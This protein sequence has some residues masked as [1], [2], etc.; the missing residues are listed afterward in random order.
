MKTFVFLISLTFSTYIFAGPGHGHGHGPVDTCKKLATDNIETSSI[1][2]GKCHISRYVKASKLDTSWKS[3]KHIKSALKDFKGK[4]E[5]VITFKNEKEK[6]GKNLY[7]FLNLK[8]GFIAAN[9]SG[10]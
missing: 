8:G 10:K 6:K 9:F 7:I 4:N 1:E 5:W 3:A 2:I